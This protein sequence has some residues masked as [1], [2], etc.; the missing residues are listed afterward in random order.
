VQAYGAHLSGVLQAQREV[1]SKDPGYFFL[2]TTGLPVLS[3][4]EQS[5]LHVDPTVLH[6]HF[7]QAAVTPD[8]L[9]YSR[10]NLYS[11]T[12]RPSCTWGGVNFA[13]LNKTDGTRTAF[14]SRFPKGQM[15]LIDFEAYHLRLIADLL[16]YDLPA[17][18]VH[19]YFGQQYFHTTALTPEQYDESKRRSFF[20]LYSD[21]DAHLP[22]FQ[23]VVTYRKQLWGHLA[24]NGCWFAPHRTLWLNRLTDPAPAKAFNY[25]VQWLETERNLRVLRDVLSRFGQAH[26]Q[27]KVVLYTYDALLIDYNVDDG[28][29]L[30]RDTV[31]LLEGPGRKFPVRVYHGPN[32]G[33]L[34]RLTL[35]SRY[36]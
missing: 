2:A 30:L 21:A 33:D 5:G 18:S 19:E 26:A 29:D 27:S 9:V 10:Y 6:A 17:G 20:A 15:V 28:P 34:T 31:A 36:L 14:T 11:A 23:Q 25:L 13:A 35:P 12:G 32:Y 4:V 16:H 1:V 24:Q 22:F 8:D 7:P 3:A